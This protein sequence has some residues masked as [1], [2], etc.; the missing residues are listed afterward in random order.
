[1]SV[2]AKMTCNEKTKKEDGG[3]RIVLFPV[4][5]GS[6]ENEEYY[7]WTPGGQAILETIN[8]SAANQFE[9]GKEYYVTFEPA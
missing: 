6:K 2:R 5:S 9:Q 8:E 7:K 1:M 4:T 3:F